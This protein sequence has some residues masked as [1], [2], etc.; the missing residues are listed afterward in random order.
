MQAFPPWVGKVS[1]ML[2]RASRVQRAVFVTV[3]AVSCLTEAGARARDLP[4]VDATALASEVARAGAELRAEAE[5]LIR[6]PGPAE[7]TERIGAQVEASAADHYRLVN[8]AIAI[9]ALAGNRGY[10]EGLLRGPLPVA[11]DDELRLALARHA[12]LVETRSDRAAEASLEELAWQCMQGESAAARLERFALVRA[13]LARVDPD[14]RREAVLLT[15]LG[16]HLSHEGDLVAAEEWTRRAIALLEPLAPEG[17]EIADCLNNLASLCRVTG[18]LD[19]ALSCS[20]R[21]L[22][23]RRTREPD[24]PNHAVA[25]V[26]LGNLRSALG[27]LSEALILYG[28]ALAILERTA[29]DSLL[30]ARCLGN[31]GGIHQARGELAEALACYRRTLRVVE[32]EEPGSRELAQCYNNLGTVLAM[33][34]EMASALAYYERDLAIT[35]VLAPDSLD[36]ATTLSNIGS[37]H[38]D[39]GNLELA[40]ACHAEALAI[41]QRL[42]PETLDVAASQASLAG[43]AFRE[44]RLDAARLYADQALALRARL[45]PGSLE[46]ASTLHLLA[47]VERLSGRLPKALD[48]ARESL[49][50]RQERAPGS[51]L[52]AQSENAVARIEG[53]LGHA[54]EAAAGHARAVATFEASRGLGPADSLGR[55][56]YFARNSYLYYDRIE[57]HLAAGQVCEA[58]DV[59]EAMRARS[60]MDEIAERGLTGADPALAQEQRTLDDER[61]RT[62]TAL[63]GATERA[64]TL[65]LRARLA[66]LELAQRDL[67]RRLR[68][69]DP[70]RAGLACPEP[71]PLDR[72]RAR[73]EPGTVLALFAVCGERTHVFLA[74]REVPVR[75]VA[76]ERTSVEV[77]E[78]VAEVLRTLRASDPACDEELRRAA[79]EFLWPL[80]PYLAGAR[81]LLL[82]PD[83]PLWLLPWQALP[84]GA[85][86]APPLGGTLAL[87]Y[88]VSGT[89]HVR[90]GGSVPSGRGVVLALGDP[91]FGLGTPGLPRIPYSGLEATVVS[92][93]LAPSRL[94][95]GVDATE[96]ALRAALPDARVV[97]LASHCTLDAARPLDSWI[98]LGDPAGASLSTEDGLLSASEVLGLDLRG[99]RLAALSGCE[100]ASGELLSGEGIVGLASAFLGAGAAS[101]VC[102]QWPV[103]D[104]SSAALMCRFYTHLRDGWRRDEALRQA[105]REVRTGRD[106]TGAPLALPSPLAWRAE[107]AHPAHWAPLVLLGD[108]GPL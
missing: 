21:T 12:L 40:R 72:I 33:S 44:G 22:A 34:G 26:G 29:P 43:I 36:L 65:T 38:A 95:L 71:A 94:L 70:L 63:L 105:A 54:A 98:A 25:L 51:S 55:G 75:H 28:E 14:P 104:D 10:A 30:W 61:A 86:A 102:A 53:D 49:R 79:R 24:S 1:P 20:L 89:L 13:G 32:R 3:V 92:E 103:T 62:Y 9:G 88:A 91:V 47:G 96:K 90:G 66:D 78:R 11:T 23:I 107:W 58:A 80:R 76:L 39:L 5:A 57:A 52:C 64:G 56:R 50:I 18:R 27:E 97:H 99:C 15:A 100:T 46:V 6:D 60:L 45:A 93:Q 42:A 101:V 31:I 82:L 69:S 41:R 59:A 67:E 106:A 17:P 73:L 16:S 77:V 37:A 108:P 74:G 7:A 84:V 4:A 35:R 85:G 81:R 8:L 19:E 83:G 87:E 2:P 48:R 68:A